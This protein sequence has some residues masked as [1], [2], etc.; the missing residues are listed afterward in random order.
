MFRVHWVSVIALLHPHVNH[1]FRT[2]LQDTKILKMFFL[3]AIEKFINRLEAKMTN[4]DPSI[5]RQYIQLLKNKY[6]KPCIWG[7]VIEFK[8]IE[9]LPE[10]NSTWGHILTH[11]SYNEIVDK[12]ASHL[13]AQKQDQKWNLMLFGKLFLTFS[14]I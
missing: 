2:L 7:K 11:K 9:I 14:L 10:Q 3:Y 12:I 1:Q 4:V 13:L 6:F 8:V 5:V